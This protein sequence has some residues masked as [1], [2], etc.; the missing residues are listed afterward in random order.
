MATLLPS[1]A[2]GAEP[3]PALTQLFQSD[4]DPCP[5]NGE[6]DEYELQLSYTNSAGNQRGVFPSALPTPLVGGSSSYCQ[7]TPTP[8]SLP[9]PMGPTALG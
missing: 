1:C 5:L 4:S 3:D 7:V 6:W 8:P 9:P 2:L